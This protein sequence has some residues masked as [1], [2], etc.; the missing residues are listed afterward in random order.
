MNNPSHS[1]ARSGGLTGAVISL[2][3]FGLGAGC[4]IFKGRTPS[5]AEVLPFSPLQIAIP[6]LGF[7]ALLLLLAQHGTDF[8]RIF[9]RSPASGFFAAGIAWILLGAAL[10]F[11]SEAG[12]DAV[13]FMLRW[14]MP[15]CILLAFTVARQQSASWL[16]LAYGLAAGAAL[17]AVCVELYRVGFPLP[18]DQKTVGRFGGLLAH[19]NQYGI[20]TSTSAAVIPVLLLSATRWRQLLGLAMLPLALVCLYQSLS[21]T[22]ILLFLLCLGA[23]F[24]LLS[25]YSMRRVVVTLLIAAA[26]GVGLVGAGSVGL[27]ILKEVSP[28][29]AKVIEDAIFDPGGTQSLDRREDVWGEALAYSRENPW[30]GLGPGV[31][32]EVLLKNHAHNLFIQAHLDTGIA[33]LIGIVLLVLGIFIRA[34]Q[35]G[36]EAL[37]SSSD[38]SDEEALRLASAVGM[39]IY[40]FGNIMSDSF[41]TATIPVFTLMAGLAFGQPPEKAAAPPDELFDFELEPHASLAR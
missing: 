8:P 4:W 40:V 12:A 30:L 31:A 21:K 15:I 11:G 5:G 35:L 33:G 7:G 20:V 39:V 14:L 10:H 27:N 37:R 18:I 41:G 28:R 36:L 17:S 2:V 32:G 3:L 29:D 23:G 25:I 38:R 13:L 26:L 34:A 22:N 24:I 19:P 1:P 16:P 6:A 9:V